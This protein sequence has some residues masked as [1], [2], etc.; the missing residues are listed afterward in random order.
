MGTD[1]A[2]ISSASAAWPAWQA[3]QAWLT[4]PSSVNAGARR[5]MRSLW[6]S[7]EIDRP[8]D[9][10]M[11]GCICRLTARGPSLQGLGFSGRFERLGGTDDA[12][13]VLSSPCPVLPVSP[14][15]SQSHALSP[16]PVDPQP[17][18]QHAQPAS[19]S[20]GLCPPSIYC[21]QCGV[22]GVY[23]SPSRVQPLGR[24]RAAR[25]TPSL[26][27]SSTTATCRWEVDMARALDL[28]AESSHGAGHCPEAC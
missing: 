28:C 24:I 6:A 7:H 2:Q 3:W 8:Q 12:I 26:Y 11:D 14:V 4:R 17:G 25:T 18:S 23:L 10:G 1:L 22:E 20:L 9:G 13:P 27:R 5:Q 16:S 21:L 19:S 15:Q